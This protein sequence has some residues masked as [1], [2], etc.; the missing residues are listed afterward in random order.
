MKATETPLISPMGTM[1]RLFDPTLFETIERF[2]NAIFKQREEIN[3]K[4]AEMFGILKELSEE[5]KSVGD[6]RVVGKNIVEP[7]KSDMAGTLEEVDREDEVRN[8]TN[9]E[10][11]RNTKK[12]LTEEKELIEGLIGIS[13]FNDSLLAMQLGKMEYEAYHSLPVEPIRKAMLKKIIPKKEDIGVIFDKKK[14]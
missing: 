1:W 8:W 7:N 5:E 3:D 6:N 2:E 10:T 4:M 9:N 14:L 12:D 11:A 13:R